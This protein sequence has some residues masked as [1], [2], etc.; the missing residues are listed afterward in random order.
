MKTLC[1][2]VEEKTYFI[3]ADVDVAYHDTLRNLDFIQVEDGF[4]KAFPAESPHMQAIYQNF[5]SHAEELILQAAGVHPVPWEQALL[6]F[7]ARVKYRPDI[8]WWLAGSTALAVRGLEVLP[9]D[10]DLI[11]DDAGAHKVGE[12]LLDCLIEPV[13]D[14]RGWISN[15]FGRAFLHARIEWVGGVDA[16]VDTPEVTDFGPTAASRLETINWR[17]HEILVPPLD[18]QLRVSERRGLIKR[19]EIIQRAMKTAE[20]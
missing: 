9:H 8:N 6:A 19:V 7:I 12:L 14:S 13:Q 18:L 10:I 11:L 4:A 2:T 1:R 3:I 16:K 5:A 17:G 20:M 15:W